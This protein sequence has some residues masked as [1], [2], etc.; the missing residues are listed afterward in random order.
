[1]TKGEVVEAFDP[2]LVDVPGLLMENEARLVDIR[3]R[4]LRYR[5]LC[6]QFQAAADELAR[7]A[8]PGA[9][10]AERASL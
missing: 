1:M 5:H 6:D 7:L 10:R 2:R 8:E 9:R 3:L 4:L